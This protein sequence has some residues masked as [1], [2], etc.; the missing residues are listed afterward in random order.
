MGRTLAA[1][2]LGLVVL[3]AGN[4]AG[5]TA[6]LRD[7]KP[8]A[9]ADRLLPGAEAWERLTGRLGTDH[10][11]AWLRDRRADLLEP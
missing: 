1:F 6:W 10:Y 3:G 4:A 5:L 2:L 11:L 9:L 7:A 8:T